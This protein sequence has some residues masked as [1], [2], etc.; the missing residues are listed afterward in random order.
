MKDW[1][2]IR[3]SDDEFIKGIYERA[4]QYQDRT[5]DEQKNQNAVVSFRK[6]RKNLRKGISFGL[7]AAAAGAI[8]FLGAGKLMLERSTDK[9]GSTP[10]VTMYRS[11]DESQ[12]EGEESDG[13]AIPQET[14]PVEVQGVITEIEEEESNTVFRL[15]TMEA[16]EQNFPEEIEVV[17]T[18]HFY[19]QLKKYQRENEI[20]DL[21]GQKVLL[22]VD[23]Y[24][25]QE[26]YIL[27]RE[28]GF[29]LENENEDGAA[30]YRNMDGDEITN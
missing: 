21:I 1:N 12:F 7:T 5:E 13:D 10:E 19:E 29:Y 25:W 28:D 20:E 27:N 9:T 8:A 26:Y 16:K 18:D 22:F 17:I 24:N 30:V 4:N 11:V 15:A 2:K 6:Q 23:E 3:K 14:Q